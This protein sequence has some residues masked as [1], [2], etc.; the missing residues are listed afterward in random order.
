MS[1]PA[2]AGSREKPLISV[3]LPAFNAEK[4]V[5]EAVQ[6]ILTQSFM[7]FELIVIDDGSR[8]GTKAILE[9]LCE[10]DD[11]IILVSRENK[12]LVTSLNEGV[13]LARGMWI[14]RMDADDIALPHRLERQLKW[15]RN[16]HADICGSWAKMFG[17]YDNR[18]IKHA[19]SDAAIRMEL[20][21]GSAFVHPSVMMKAELV[22]TMRY[23]KAWEN[24]EDYDLWERIARSG[25][26]MTNVPEV[27]LLY[28]QHETQISTV[29]SSRSRQQ[30]LTQEIRRRYWAAM[31]DSLGL[32]HVW[33]KEVLKL[34]EPSP[35]AFD[36]DKID[37]VFNKLLEQNRGE[38]RAVVFDHMTRSY[39]R[40]AAYCRDV[41][42]RWRRLNKRYGNRPTW[43]TRLTL[44]A[45]SFLRVKPD[46]RLFMWLKQFYFRLTRF[47]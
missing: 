2:H 20:L 46:G 19:Q 42:C 21:F 41:E 25:W 6:S 1:K 38:A 26:I 18:I 12:G 5:R 23:D 33:S 34:R 39:F 43:G 28:R 44:L 17:A 47:T 15:L 11:R 30:V 8:D 3:V 37:M 9:E 14:A 24:A 27:L 4:Y 29:T 35:P 16:T 7:D 45:L 40:A 22:K 36:M 10:Q 13:A 32:E 31:G